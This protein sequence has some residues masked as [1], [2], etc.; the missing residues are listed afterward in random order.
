MK[1]KTYAKFYFISIA[2][3]HFF[4]EL[5][6]STTKKKHLQRCIRT[7]QTQNMEMNKVDKEE[8]FELKKYF[9]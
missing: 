4:I 8:I 3:K 6:Y 7:H 1:N 9:R 5:K 2:D